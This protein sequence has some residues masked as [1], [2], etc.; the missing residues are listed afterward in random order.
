MVGRNGDWNGNEDYF[1]RW[2]VGEGR[3]RVKVMGVR[4]Y[5]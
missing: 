2:E 4:G 3:E 1:I 5:W